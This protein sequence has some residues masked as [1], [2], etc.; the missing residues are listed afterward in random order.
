M[1]KEGS[2]NYCRYCNRKLVGTGPCNCI[3]RMENEKLWSKEE[4]RKIS[5]KEREKV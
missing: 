1:L 5:K 2:N 4:R 3:Q